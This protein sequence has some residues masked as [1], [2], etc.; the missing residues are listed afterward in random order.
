MRHKVD[1]TFFLAG[2]A[3]GGMIP[4]HS[5][6]NRILTQLTDMQLNTRLTQLFATVLTALA[7]IFSSARVSANDD[8]VIGTLSYARGCRVLV[9]GVQQPSGYGVHAGDSIKTSPSCKAQ[10]RLG[11]GYGYGGKAV[12]A[13]GDTSDNG[14]GRGGVIVIDPNTRVRVYLDGNSVLAAVLIGGVHY[15]PGLRP[16]PDENPAIVDGSSGDADPLPFLAAFGFGNFSFPSIGGG[17]TANTTRVAVKNS[18]G[19]IVGYIVKDSNGTVI[20]FTDALGNVLAVANPAGTP[21][22]GVFGKGA[23]I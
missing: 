12:V 21:V 15:F 2:T 18:Q 3:G 1:T 6:H 11:S 9:N 20:A 5:V 8:A 4:A 7:L 16:G 10:I 14:G 23:T 19:V 22:S 13:Q 17:G